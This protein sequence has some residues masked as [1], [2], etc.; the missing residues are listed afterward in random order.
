MHHFLSSRI[1]AMAESATLAMHSLTQS[2][3]AQGHHICDLTLGEPNFITPYSIQE[4]AKQAIDTG[5]YFSYP[6]V[7]GYKDLRE[8]IA[9]KLK[10][11]N[12]IVCEPNQIIV[13]TGAKQS[14]SNL[15]FCLLDP[16]DEIIV[17]TP[18]WVSYASNIE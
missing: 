17:F 9:K 16:G 6:P 7:A 8:A 1:R 14:L 10:H 12:K 3:Q 4:A 13:S 5:K 15:F 2:L 11:E 18:Y